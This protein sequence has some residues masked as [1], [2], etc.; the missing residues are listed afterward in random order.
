ML[1]RFQLVHLGGL[2]P[3]RATCCFQTGLMLRGLLR[4]VRFAGS[5][6]KRQLPGALGQ[7]ID[8][9]PVAKSLAQS[10]DRPRV[11]WN[12]DMHLTAIWIHCIGSEAEGY[13]GLFSA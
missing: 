7:P 1:T 5:E 2:L 9:V 11:P 8:V 13:I 4:N 3:R 12:E 6:P 10:N